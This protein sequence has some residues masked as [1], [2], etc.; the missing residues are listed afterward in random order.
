MFISL[1]VATFKDS[2][3]DSNNKLV[4]TYTANISDVYPFFAKSSHKITF[5]KAYIGTYQYFWD[6]ISKLQKDLN[7]NFTKDSKLLTQLQYDF[8]KDSL[9]AKYGAPT[10]IITGLAKTKD[11]NNEIRFYESA[12]KIVFLGKTIDFK[13]ILSC[14]ITDDPQFIP[15]RSTTYGAGLSF[16]GIG[17]GG[18]ETVSTPGK[19]LHN[20]VVNIKNDNLAVPY[21]HIVMGQN[22]NKAQEIAS[23]F[24][25]IIR[26]NSN[27]KTTTTTQRRRTKR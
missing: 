2:E 21:F 11:I 17:I 19:T 23:A 20:Y 9:E 7:T 6:F 27:R 18:S 25:Y 3:Y 26:H 10:N 24:E 16:F 12:Q 15:G 22:A 8:S 5:S 1:G 4:R 14:E 13:D